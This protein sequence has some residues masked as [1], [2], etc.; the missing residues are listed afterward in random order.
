MLQTLSYGGEQLLLRQ[1]NRGFLHLNHLVFMHPTISG[2]GQE[3]LV[4]VLGDLNVFPAAES[5]KV[6]L[7]LSLDL[8]A[9]VQFHIPGILKLAVNR[10]EI[11]LF[12]F[13]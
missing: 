13:I 12:F 4:H 5:R 1:T 9:I 2:V 7:D 10:T 11:L 3:A 6:S 8:L